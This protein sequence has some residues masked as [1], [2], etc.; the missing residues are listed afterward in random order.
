MDEFT[1]TRTGVT[2]NKRW[3]MTRAHQIAARTGD[4]PN[5]LRS[6][7]ATA[8]IETHVEALA[9]AAR[10]DNSLRQRSSDSLRAEISMIRN[11]DRPSSRHT[12]RIN[13]LTAA[14]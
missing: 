8:K 7:W 5:A 4:F 1:T 3:V 14:L 11:I 13:Q 6:A 2:V 12:T 9:F 10:T